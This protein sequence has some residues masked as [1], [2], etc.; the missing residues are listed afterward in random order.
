MN[1][2]IIFFLGKKCVLTNKLGK[3]HINVMG[4]EVFTEVIMKSTNFWDITLCS[5]PLSVNRRFG[6]T[7]RFH[8]QGGRNAFSKN[9]QASRWQAELLAGFLL[10]LLL[11][12]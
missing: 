4:F 2:Y 12:P 1:K 3:K 10:N 9:K 8:L 11:R 5:R 7:N 6:E